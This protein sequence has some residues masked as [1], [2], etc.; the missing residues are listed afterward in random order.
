MKML[1][2]LKV[3]V[4]IFSLFMLFDESAF[5]RAGRGQSYRSSSYRSSSS[6]GGYRSSYSGYHRSSYGSGYRHSGYTKD[7]DED[8]LLGFLFLGVLMFAIGYAIYRNYR[9]KNAIHPQSPEPAI[10]A[11]ARTRI[12]QT[13]QELDP[14][15]SMEIFL[16]RAKEIFLR[17]QEAWSSGDMTPV[18]NFLSQG[19]YNRF[20]IQL[21][22]MRN[23]EGLKNVMS[24]V[25]VVSMSPIGISVSSPHLTLHV[26]LKAEA[27]D[28]TVPTGIN[29]DELQRLLKKTSVARFTEVYSFTRK[30]N[31]HSDSSRDL[32]KGQCPRCGFVPENFS[33][34]NK[35]PSCGALYNSGEYDWVLSEITQ[36][37][38]WKPTSAD[39][40]SGLADGMSRQVIEDRA[41]YLFWRWIQYR[42]RGSALPL[43]RDATDKM[44][45]KLASPAQEYLGELAVG[46]VDLKRVELSDEEF[47][48]DVLIQWSASVEK[49]NEPIH[50]DHRMYLVLPKDA[51]VETNFAD[52]GCV[53]CGAPVPD[54][55]ALNCAY[56]GALLPEAHSDWLLDEIRK[57]NR[58]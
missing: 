53:Q 21:E 44:K 2:L 23:M 40:V 17:L 24:D 29:D 14:N 10:D 22:I 51:N 15:F 13:I 27:R 16:E 8:A 45:A 55:D 34:V 50:F 37:E 12:L 58:G 30:L 3:L 32:L 28:V 7:S 47:R 38:E 11:D 20:K 19:V 52:H 49:N 4:F 5:A 57:K 31:A 1:K 48:A 35:C 54:T 56:C 36:M 42:V 39:E 46:A 43:M 9:Q 18:R 26:A 6:S 41:S 33:Q 25:N